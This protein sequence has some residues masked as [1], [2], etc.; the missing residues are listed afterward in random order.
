MKR[1][2][3]ARENR[4][5]AL[6]SIMS[7]RQKGATTRREKT[8]IFAVGGP[9]P[10]KSSSLFL[11]ARNAPATN[12]L[13]CHGQPWTHSTEQPRSPTCKLH[14]RLH[15][16]HRTSLPLPLPLV[17]SLPYKGR[18]GG[19]AGTSEGTARKGAWDRQTTRSEE[20]EDGA[21]LENVEAPAC[22]QRQ[23][24]RTRARHKM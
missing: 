9:P 3:K 4:G 15:S 1:V 11:R 22:Q 21:V 20:G 19:D 18:V 5:Q 13:V 6:P 7:G 24:P 8:R 12:S 23:L 14:P 2:K 16:V 10:G 17:F